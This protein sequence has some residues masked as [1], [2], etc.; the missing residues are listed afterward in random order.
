MQRETGAV[1][2]V[3]MR[4]TSRAELRR[5]LEVGQIA[6]ADPAGQD[7][8]QALIGAD[9]PLLG[10]LHVLQLEPGRCHQ[11][12]GPHWRFPSVTVVHLRK[13]IGSITGPRA[14]ALDRHLWTRPG[15]D[16]AW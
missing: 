3:R 4:P 2:P 13:L 9:L 5:T 15:G 6:P 10:S 16:L 1:G 12:L 7:P 11:R 14:P 8:Q